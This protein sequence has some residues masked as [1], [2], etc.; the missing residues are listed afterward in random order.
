MNPP[1]QSH[2]RV[3]DWMD[4]QKADSGTIEISIVVPAYNEERRLPPTLI[5]IVD[6]C[7]RTYRSYEIIVV[8]DGSKDS[9]SEVVKKF[10]RVRSQVRLIQL[11]RNY[12]KGHAVK[13]GVL[14]SHG[15]RI[16]FADA[17]GAA[18]IEELRRLE[19]ALR[20]GADIAIGS[21]AIASHETKVETSLHR[22]LLGRLFNRCV[23]VV[24]LP[25]ISDTQCGFKLFTHAAAE[26]LFKHQTANRFSFDVELLFLARRTEM[27]I[28]EIPINWTNIPGS[29]VNLITD[30]LRMF[31]DVF[32]FRIVHRT[33]TPAS[34]RS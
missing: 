1:E 33:I 3:T 14:N 19:C 2:D 20:E 4:R 15:Q 16:L 9:S 25:G 31:R 8:D 23:N 13:V 5:D 29:K 30:A 22:K 32:R 10:E 24:L 34:F 27:K 18:P 6:Y 28:A 11:P 17:D 12:G 7:D 26:F 21:R